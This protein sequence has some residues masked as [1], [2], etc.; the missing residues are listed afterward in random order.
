MKTLDKHNAEMWKAYS[1]H[2]L[3]GRNPNGIECPHCRKELFD[4]SPAA[5]L[6]SSPPKK[7]IHCMGCG[8]IGQR[9]T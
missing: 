3:D 6:G 1:Q 8:Y 9:L 7:D 4:S 5:I 2:R